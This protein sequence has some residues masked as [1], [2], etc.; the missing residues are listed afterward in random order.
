M[1]AKNSLKVYVLEHYYHVYNRG[2]AKQTIFLD[3]EDKKK[4]LQI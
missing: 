4:F 3:A 2:V 1:P